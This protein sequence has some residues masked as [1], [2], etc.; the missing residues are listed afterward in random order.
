LA[1]EHTA[2]TP[3]TALDFSRLKVMK[4]SEI[5][6]A[7]LGHRIFA[8]SVSFTVSKLEV[9]RLKKLHYVYDFMVPNLKTV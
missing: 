3:K 5:G 7:D 9:F 6:F 8:T 4:S 1:G 2:Y